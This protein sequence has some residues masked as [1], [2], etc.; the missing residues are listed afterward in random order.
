MWDLVSDT[1]QNRQASPHPHPL[2]EALSWT[3]QSQGWHRAEGR[4]LPGFWVMSVAGGPPGSVEG[5]PEQRALSWAW[6]GGCWSAMILTHI[7]ASHEKEKKSLR[8][9]KKIDT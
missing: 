4:V 6:Q 9:E 8:K 3:P 1:F 2:G 5:F 7:F